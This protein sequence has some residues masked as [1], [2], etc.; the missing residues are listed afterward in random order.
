[1]IFTQ[2]KLI[3]IGVA[4]V[5]AVGAFTWFYFEGKKEAREEC[6]ADQAKVINLWEEK[7]NAAQEKNTVLARDLTAT[8]TEL[9]KSKAVRTKKIIKYVKEDPNSDVIIF[10]DVGLQL[11]NEAQRGSKTTDSK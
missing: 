8:L 2:V 6:L 4:A 11:L 9:E 1:M 3:V 5:A 7:L 10:D